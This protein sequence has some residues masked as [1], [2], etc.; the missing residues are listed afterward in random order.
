MAVSGAERLVSAPDPMPWRVT[1]S[2]ARAPG[3]GLPKTTPQPAAVSR[4]VLLAMSGRA[5]AGTLRCSTPWSERGVPTGC[6]NGA[7]GANTAALGEAVRPHPGPEAS[8]GT[9]S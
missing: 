6:T 8:E 9:P 7:S 3:P 2:T 1:R 4:T 5:A